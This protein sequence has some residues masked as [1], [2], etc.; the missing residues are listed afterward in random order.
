MKL[1]RTLKFHSLRKGRVRMT[2]NKYNLF[3]LTKVQRTIPNFIRRTFFQQKWTA[4][5]LT[6]AYHGEHIKEQK[7]QRM[8]DRRLRSVVDMNPRYMAHNDGAEQATGRGS[9]RDTIRAEDVTP[10]HAEGLERKF[11][12]RGGLS[13]ALSP[14]VDKTEVDYDPK[15]NR[16]F[17]ETNVQESQNPTPYMNMS[18]APIERRIDVAI[19]RAMFAS[20]TRQARNM[21]IH[22][23][24]KVNGQPMNHATYLLNPGDMFQVEP[25]A[26]MFATGKIK[27]KAAPQEEEPAAPR[28]KK[29]RKRKAKAAGDGEATEAAAAPEAD[30]GSLEPAEGEEVDA[31][32]T[33]DKVSPEDT[34]EVLQKRLRF[35]ARHARELLQVDKDDMPVKKKRQMRA[36]MK[37]AKA[38]SSKLGRKDGEEA[39]TD[40]L[41]TTISNT[42]KELAINDP[43]I[44]ER[45]EQSGA[46]TAEQTAE[47]KEAAEPE[48]SKPAPAQVAAAPPKPYQF[49][50][51]E[52]E[53]LEEMVREYEENPVDPTKPYKTPWEPRPF[54]SPFAFIPRYL[55]VNQNICAAV[56]LRHPVARQGMSEIP[57]PFP[58]SVQEL[59]F[60]WYLRRR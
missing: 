52:Q 14:L 40:D 10:W 38:I 34:P 50:D 31:E 35:L 44:A 55:E 16:T 5:A 17:A 1:R 24:V 43:K 3:N 30:E 28:P 15:K 18:F 36:F 39:I 51:E 45:A 22:G 21:V 56:Y 25:D 29:S 27:P 49:S 32:A 41:V 11:K 7:W 12:L 59:A 54:M 60:N 46:F 2:W 13:K 26:V 4:K 20:S 48:A 58:P 37:Q 19:F 8:F 47:A 23:K 42:L 6:R 33:T 9:G 57:S 53:R